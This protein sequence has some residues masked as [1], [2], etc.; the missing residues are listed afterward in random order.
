MM[1][2]DPYYLL[3]TSRDK[4]IKKIIVISEKLYRA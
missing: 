3:H 4:K 2:E 1:A